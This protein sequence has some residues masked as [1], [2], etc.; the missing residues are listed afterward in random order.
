MLFKKIT[1]RG[2]KVRSKVC[3][4]YVVLLLGVTIRSDTDSDSDFA[5][6][7]NFANGA[8]TSR[9]NFVYMLA[10]TQRVS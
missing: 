9:Q 5:T 3:N 2:T 8:K 1:I 4:S 6:P 10:K 7:L